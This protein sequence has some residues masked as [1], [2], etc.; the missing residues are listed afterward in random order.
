M[1]FIADLFTILI[2]RAARGE[3]DACLVSALVP[4]SPKCVCVLNVH[5]VFSDT[6]IRLYCSGLLTQL[7][8]T[9]SVRFFLCASRT[10][11]W[12]TDGSMVTR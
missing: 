6:F 1:R 8:M 5:Y 4:P 11:V 12:I 7:L 3:T 10:L 9:A 2:L